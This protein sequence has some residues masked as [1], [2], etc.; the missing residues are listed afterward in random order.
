MIGGLW[1]FQFLDITETQLT[2]HYHL[3]H[4]YS[5]TLAPH[6]KRYNK[7]FQNF[8]MHFCLYNYWSYRYENILRK[9]F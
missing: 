6:I 9:L 2:S 8:R 5:T 3:D 1:S 4:V 7:Q